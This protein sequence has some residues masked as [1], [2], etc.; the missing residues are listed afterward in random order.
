MQ[1]T[2]VTDL[3]NVAKHTPSREREP[4]SLLPCLYP[5][6]PSPSRRASLSVAGAHPHRRRRLE[7]PR[8]VRPVIAVGIP[9]RQG[10]VKSSALPALSNRRHHLWQ[11]A[12]R[13]WFELEEDVGVARGQ[14][15]GGR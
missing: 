1:A 6:P 9:P 8:A 14:Q 13:A 4:R 3:R 5:P 11:E 10:K 15:R 2:R 7:P 12:A